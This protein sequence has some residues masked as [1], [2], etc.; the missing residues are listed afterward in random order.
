MIKPQLNCWWA[1]YPRK[2]TGRN[3][4]DPL[5][6]IILPYIEL[7]CRSGPDCNMVPGDY[8]RLRYCMKALQWLVRLLILIGIMI[9]NR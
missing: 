8:Q 5:D 1:E 9:K 6:S 2:E 7:L 4:I 3:E